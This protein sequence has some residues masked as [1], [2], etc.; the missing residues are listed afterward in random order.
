[1]EFPINEGMQERV[2]NREIETRNK[3]WPRVVRLFRNGKAE[4]KRKGN[5]KGEPEG[6]L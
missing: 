5:K 6:F 1:M 3:T 4:K 2:R